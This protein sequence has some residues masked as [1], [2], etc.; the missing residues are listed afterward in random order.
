MLVVQGGVR[1]KGEDEFVRISSIPMASLDTI[2]GW[3]DEVAELTYTE[4]VNPFNWKGIIE[5]WVRDDAFYMSTNPDTGS[6]K[7]V[8][9][10]MFRDEPTGE[11]DEE[12][13]SSAFE[14]SDVS[15]SSEDEE[16]DDDFD[17]N[18][19]GDSDVSTGVH[20]CLHAGC[21]RVQRRM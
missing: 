18:V 8:G 3:L 9:W 1:E 5:D 10:D 13:E 2:K 4:S 19:E 6:P 11:E 16:D 17:D 12:E 20:A 14:G 7:P 21:V 15:A